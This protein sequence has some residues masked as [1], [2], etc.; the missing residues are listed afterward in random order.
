MGKPKIWNISK[1]ADCR[2]KRIQIWDSGYYN[3]HIADTFDAQ[4]LEFGLGSFGAR[5]KFSDFTIFKTL[6]LSQFP[7]DFIQTLCKVF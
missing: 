7:S 2:A 5:C 3:A 4:F 1:T 6:L